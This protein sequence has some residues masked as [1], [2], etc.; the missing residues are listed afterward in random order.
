LRPQLAAATAFLAAATPAVEIRGW[1]GTEQVLTYSQPSVKLV[2]GT[3]KTWLHRDY[4]G[5]VRAI[6]DTAGAKVESAVYKPFGEQSEWV[7]PGNTSPETKGWIG[8]RFD[9][10][11][12]HPVGR[13]F[14]S[15]PPRFALNPKRPFA[16]HQSVQMSDTRPTPIRRM[17][18]TQKPRNPPD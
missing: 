13:V 2:N 1:L 15:P 7:Q 12:R 8:E 17:S 10:R 14:N 5:S 6:T 11:P 16:R 18:Y 4:L 9:Y 3:T